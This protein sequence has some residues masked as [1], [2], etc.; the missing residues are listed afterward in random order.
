M[1]DSNGIFIA[2]ARLLIILSSAGFGSNNW[3][4]RAFFWILGAG[5]KWLTPSVGCSWVFLLDYR[6]LTPSWQQRLYHLLL[7]PFTWVQLSVFLQLPTSYLLP[8]LILDYLGNLSYE[9]F[10]TGKKDTF[11]NSYSSFSVTPV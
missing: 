10:L 8:M 3:G 7:G 4:F 9:S 5:F 11:R 2:S 6:V 1:L